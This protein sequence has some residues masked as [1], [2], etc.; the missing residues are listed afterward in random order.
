MKKDC[1]PS[2]EIERNST[3][4]VESMLEEKVHQRD[5]IEPS[6]LSEAYSNVSPFWINN[7]KTSEN[8]I[9][10]NYINISYFQSYFD[11]VLF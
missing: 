5:N 2:K 9:T 1:G 8:H 10:I 3:P 11:V 6:N 7:K 4:V